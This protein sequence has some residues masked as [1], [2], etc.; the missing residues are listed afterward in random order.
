MLFGPGV[1]RSLRS[2][3]TSPNNPRGSV[4]R[5]REHILNNFIYSIAIMERAEPIDQFSPI[6]I[7]LL[8]FDGAGWRICA[9]KWGSGSSEV[10]TLE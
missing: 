7:I 9:E 8:Y 6:S 1:R 4:V 3:V 2:T 10:G 5:N